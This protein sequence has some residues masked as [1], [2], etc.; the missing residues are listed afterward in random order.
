MKDLTAI[1]KNENLKPKEL[2]LLLLTD[3]HEK[4]KSDKETLSEKDKAILMQR[5]KNFE[6]REDCYEYNSYI[7][8]YFNAAQ[9]N[10]DVG[11][12]DR[13][14]VRIIEC[15]RLSVLSY[16]INR[17]N[18]NLI[19]DQE[20]N[21]SI[22]SISKHV[23]ENIQFYIQEL[24]KVYSGLL[25]YKKIVDKSTESVG[26]D[27]NYFVNEVIKK[28]TEQ[29]KKHNEN[30]EKLGIEEDFYIDLNSVSFNQNLYDQTIEFLST[31]EPFKKA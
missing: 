11:Y 6:S 27:I 31:I 29:V 25:A 16:V 17:L 3:L 21:K 10:I 5:V 13:E 14:T 22:R 1:L 19:N 4:K 23:L 12:C 18:I 15:L 8:P 30:I 26:L 7:S 24:K 20:T 9:V 28:I 2:A